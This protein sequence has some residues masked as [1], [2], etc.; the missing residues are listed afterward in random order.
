MGK[1]SV[2]NSCY[3]G[4]ALGKDLPLHLVACG[5]HVR[6]HSG[7]V[8]PVS[9]PTCTYETLW[10]VLRLYL[11]YSRQCFK[12]W[13]SHRGKSRHN[14]TCRIFSSGRKV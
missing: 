1:I 8:G 14:L 6:V 5:V 12:R 7:V 4:T 3:S 13:I 11:D 10:E 9:A 2:L